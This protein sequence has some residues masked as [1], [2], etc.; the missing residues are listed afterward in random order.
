MIISAS[1]RSDIPAFYAAWFMNRIRAGYCLVPNPFNPRQI[2][3]VSLAP[4]DVDAIVFWT[5]NP[6][7]LMG[8]LAALDEAGFKYSFLFTIVGHPRQIDPKSP[9]TAAATATFRD[10][11]ARLGPERVI[12]RYDPIV[13]STLTR[14]EFHLENFEALARQLSG[15]TRRVVI[16]TVNLYRKA[17]P[18]L[19]R[20]QGT[21]AEL[22]PPSESDLERLIP[23][24]REVAGE[25]GMGIVSCAEELDLRRF[26]VEPGKCIDDGLLRDALGIEV[27]GKKDPGQRDACGCVASRDIGVYDTCL[28][29][30]A[31]CYATRSFERARERYHAHDPHS[32][33][34]L[35]AP[36][37]PAL[38]VRVLPRMWRYT[39]DKRHSC[40]RA[41]SDAFATGSLAVPPARRPPSCSQPRADCSPATTI[42]QH[43]DNNSA[44]SPPMRRN[45]TT[46][47]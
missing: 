15:S 22:V 13:L 6:R 12:W 28:F 46:L 10:L 11:A 9:S 23:K 30:C 19:D 24:M 33:S 21:P 35:S 3:R 39:R 26:G 29:G 1:R 44:T 47:R 38:N 41:L 42:S 34:L 45:I 43:R 17:K 37:G 8:R 2:S 14:A 31:Y 32:P 25:H 5:R 36:P 16:S 40:D 27:C 18:R 7:P 20:L 4:A